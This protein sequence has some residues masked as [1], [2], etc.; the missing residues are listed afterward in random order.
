[1]KTRQYLLLLLPLALAGG[2]IE[3]NGNY[4]YTPLNTIAIEGIKTDTLFSVDQ[5]DTL[6]IAPGLRFDNEEPARLGYEWKLNYEV[7]GT[8]A[9]L[10]ARVDAM[11]N[12][13]TAYYTASLRVMDSTTNLKYY[14]NFRVKVTTSVSNGLFILSERADESAALSFQRRDKPNAP[15]VHDLFEEANPTYGALGRK[16]RQVFYAGLSG[17][18]LGVVCREGER[19]ISILNPATLVLQ[20]YYSREAIR[21]G[22]DGEFTPEC[23]T[24][25]MGGMVYGGGKIYSYNYM[26]NAALYRPV[27]VDGDAYD[28][29]WTDTDSSIDSYAWL[30]YDNK[31]QR[32]VQLE[33]GG[34]P[35]LYD[36]VVPLT[37]EGDLPTAGQRFLAGGKSGW[38]VIRAITHDPVTGKAYFYGF[39][40]E[41]EFDMNTWEVLIVTTA[42]R[43]SEVEDLVDENTLCFYNAEYW[44]LA[45]GGT[46]KRL[47]EK[48]TAPLVWF[49]APA[50]QE[51]TAILSDKATASAK[52]LFI[53]TRDGAK[54]YIHVIDI[55]TKEPLEEPLEMDGKIVS[56]LVR[57]T[58][59]H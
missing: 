20:R 28:F 21:G 2:C 38:S 10:R 40:M 29:A 7:I 3:D 11:P 9:V 35:L 19:P 26:N 31:G 41:F 24:L 37:V 27:P 46:V 4:D 55:A 42:T 18:Q 48:S 32:F 51:V 5:F 33:P 57:G 47:H 16:P 53:A 1:M 6:F 50:G 36:K 54:S 25:Y 45:N 12:T 52:R 13:T 59:S 43:F 39:A 22:Y 15:L 14:K 58:W 23:L 44:Y 17:V 30:A 49:E 34:D 8:G 56:M